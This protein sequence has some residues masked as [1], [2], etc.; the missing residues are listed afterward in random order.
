[1]IGTYHLNGHRWLRN[2]RGCILGALPSGIMIYWEE[3]HIVTWPFA[4]S[5]SL[6]QPPTRQHART[7][8]A[9]LLAHLY[10]LCNTR[11]TRPANLAQLPV[12]SRD[13]GLLTL[14]RWSSLEHLYLILDR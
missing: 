1:M 14:V 5:V 11:H 13:V 7:R 10:V 8:K 12:V 4:R 2:R 3:F 9:D 6:P